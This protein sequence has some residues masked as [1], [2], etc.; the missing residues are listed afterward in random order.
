MKALFKSRR[1]HIVGIFLLVLVM[2]AGTVLLLP[3]SVKAVEYNEV[4]PEFKYA[5]I[6]SDVETEYKINSYTPYGKY[7]EN[8]GKYTMETDAYVAWLKKDDLYVAYRQ[9]DIGST[10]DDTLTVETSI[11][12]FEAVGNGSKYFTASAGVMIR[13]SLD[14]ASPMVLMHIREGNVAVLCRKSVGS[15][16]Y[17]TTS[18][19]APTSVTGLKISKKGEK[20]VCSYKLEGLDWVDFKTVKMDWNGP[21]LGGLTLHCSDPKNPVIAEF[22]GFKAIGSGTYTESSSSAS[23][24]SSTESKTDWEDAPMPENCLL[25]ETFTDSKIS[26]RDGKTPDKPIWKNFCGKIVTEENGNNLKYNSMITAEDYS[27]DYQWT[28]YSTSM[29]FRITPDTDPSDDDNFSLIVRAKAIETTGRYGYQFKFVSDLDKTTKQIKCYLEV[30]RIYRSANS[31]G[32]TI[33]AKTEVP[34]FF[35]YKTH[36][37]R[38]DAVDNTLQVYYDEELLEFNI[39]N[40]VTSVITDTS[41]V[42]LATGGIGIASSDFTD[43]YFDNVIVTKLDDPVGGDYDNFIGGNWNENVPQYAEKFSEKYGVSLY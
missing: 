7:K 13:G 24:D 17:Y 35:D 6:D 37:V 43:V 20:Y 22:D 33:M 3:N 34:S 26:E 11:T 28:D 12:S 41:P 5:I 29:D 38:V 14:P 19:A 31:E 16:M 15:T 8:N 36:N 1:V 27:G 2:T 40:T 21:F 4:N 39:N 9:Y 23:Q 42:V 25:Y 32:A 30:R 10:K 18:L